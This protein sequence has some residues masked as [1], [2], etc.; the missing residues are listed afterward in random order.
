MKSRSR[1]GTCESPQTAA[2]VSILLQWVTHNRLSN[3]DTYNLRESEEGEWLLQYELEPQRKD[4]GERLRK[5][6]MLYLLPRSCDP[7]SALAQLFEMT[8]LQRI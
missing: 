8:V 1:F 6:T 3:S 4:L 7:E 5:L 2:S